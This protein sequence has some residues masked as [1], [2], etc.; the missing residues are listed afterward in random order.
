[1]SSRINVR[2]LLEQN[3]QLADDVLAIKVDGK[4]V[5]LHSTIEA[6]A[7]YTVVRAS[8]KDGLYVIRHSTAHV[9]ADAVQKLF[10][11]TKVTIGPAIEDGFYYDF[12]KPGGGFTEE[13]LGKIE[14]AMAAI[15]KSN[16]PFRKETISRD[17]AIA[18][19]EKMGETFK[20]E[21]I[22]SIPEGEE[23]SLYK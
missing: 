7:T 13:D 6:G 2:S 15:V 19:F 18:L 9:M 5:D 20:L 8:D 17:D 16:T 23:I 3:G 10:P 12:D 4:L 22:R 14:K 21:I 1:M 11:G